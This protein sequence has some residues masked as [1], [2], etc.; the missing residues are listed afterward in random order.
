MSSLASRTRE[1]VRARPFVFDALRAG[2]VNYSAAARTLDVDG[3]VEAVAT[4]LRRYAGELPEYAATAS[5]AR[6]SMESR[7]GRVTDGGDEPLL[8]VGEV[9]YAK[10]AGSATG[11]VAT[12]DVDA[13]S[14]E[15]VLGTLRAE[16]IEVAAAGFADESIVLVVGRRNGPNAVR[17][18]EAAFEQ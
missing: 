6:V 8:T 10:G 4:A 17:A 3:D 14:F 7:L 1:A 12:G 9:A 16:E 15:R 5:G 13:V 11:I 2:V 18:V